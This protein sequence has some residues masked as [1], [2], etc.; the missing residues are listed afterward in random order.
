MTRPAEA[1]DEA[2]RELAALFPAIASGDRRAFAA[3]YQRTSAKLYGVALRILGS[4]TDAQEV[5]QDVYVS[6]WRNAGRFRADRASPITWLAVLARNR[7]IDRIRGRKPAAASLDEAGHPA[8]D[9]LNALEQLEQAG[10]RE[11]LDHCLGELDEQPRRAIVAAF[12]DGA[13]H[14]QLAQR[15]AVPLGTLKSRIRRALIALRM[16]LES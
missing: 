9:D 4:E 15:E 14:S 7:A 3:L 11:R 13:S 16:C 8:S 2:R 6:V 1:S 10:E 5:L 12:L